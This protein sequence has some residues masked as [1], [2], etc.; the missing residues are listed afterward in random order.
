MKTGEALLI[1]GA[2][3]AGAYILTQK[4]AAGGGTTTILPGPDGG[5][6]PDIAF[7]DITFPEIKFPEWP[8][9]DFPAWPKFELPVIPE[10]PIPEMPD[11][12]PT[13]GYM[14]DPGGPGQLP[15]YAGPSYFKFLGID[16]ADYLAQ[17][18][19]GLITSEMLQSF[20]DADVLPQIEGGGFSLPD[21][22][23]IKGELTDII[24]DYHL[25]L[26]SFE[27]PEFPGWPVMPEFPGWPEIP[28]L[29]TVPTLPTLPTVPT[30]GGIGEG[31]GGWLAGGIESLVGGVITGVWDVGAEERAGYAA[32]A[33]A[34][35]APSG[36]T[37]IETWM[38]VMRIVDGIEAM[39]NTIAG[40]GA[41]GGVSPGPGTRETGLA[42]AA[43]I[44]EGMAAG[45]L[46]TWGMPIVSA[47]TKPGGTVDPDDITGGG[48][49]LF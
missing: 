12:I 7:P 27:L 32:F 45:E 24:P 17:F 5:G 15:T 22:G 39:A 20:I 49:W 37:D 23:G 28:T 18:E 2:L 34:A 47:A 46:D 11:F 9:F 21:A 43:A 1:V 6:Y 33:E 42:E 8:K 35:T 41:L 16:P 44:M 36:L 3:G 19:A 38:P 26:P 29:P 13:G 40:G 25:T 48:E 10:L 31:I 30:A 4:Q 14:V